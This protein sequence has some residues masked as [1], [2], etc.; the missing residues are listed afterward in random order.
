MHIILFAGGT[1][2]EGT[3]VTQ[4]LS[5]G[6]LIVAAD[7]GASTALAMGYAPALV[8]GD[9][10]SLT[11]QTRIEL[12]RLDCQFVSA[13]TEKDETDTELA[14]QVACQQGASR[15]TILGAL[16]G[17]RF[18]H[19][20]ANFQ[21][22]VGYSTLPVEIVDGNSRG[23]LLRG[24]GTT[25]ITGRQGD[26]LSL[27]PLTDSATGVQTEHLYYPL[28]HETLSFGKPRGISNVLQTTQA[29]V[30]LSAGLLLLIHTSI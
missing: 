5:E 7:G 27:L 6:E 30:S 13:R 8:V 18:E 20:M 4:A 14:I 28:R 22:L 11:E 2:Q 21:L 10:D 25:S 1:V 16:G 3:A 24:P 15:I 9:F 12:E 19:T 26:L 17:T 29:S 23:W